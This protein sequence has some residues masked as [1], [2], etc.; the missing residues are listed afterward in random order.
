MLVT[1]IDFSTNVTRTELDGENGD[2]APTIRGIPTDARPVALL[3]R[4]VVVATTSSPWSIVVV[5]SGRA[6]TI[7]QTSAPDDAAVYLGWLR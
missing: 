7:V 4:D 6:E 5:R 3:P 2:R 1:R